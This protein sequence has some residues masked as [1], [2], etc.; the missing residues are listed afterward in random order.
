MVGSVIDHVVKSFISPTVLVDI[1]ALGEAVG[2]G[3]FLEE[4]ELVSY[5]VLL[6]H[7]RIHTDLLDDRDVS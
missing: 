6:A 7:T 1:A 4:L 2:V 3:S 5:G